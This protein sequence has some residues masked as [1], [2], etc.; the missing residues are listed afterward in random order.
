MPETAKMIA[1]LATAAG[2]SVAWS[3]W[4]QHN[5]FKLADNPLAVLEH[6]HL[7]LISLIVARGTP[8]K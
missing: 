2:L 7:G 4:P 1:G 5:Q 6:Y 8:K 3:M